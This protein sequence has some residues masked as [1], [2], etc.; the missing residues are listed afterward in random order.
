VQHN[1]LL[2]CYSNS[3][4]VYAAL[5]SPRLAL[6]V[7]HELFLTPTAML[8]DYV[9][10]AA[11][12]LEKP[13]FWSSGRGDAVM[14]G[15]QVVPPQHARHSDYDLC[16]DLGR[17]LGQV[18]PDAVEQ[19]WDDWLRGAETSFAELLAREQYWLPAV[20]QRGR[21][22]AVDPRSGEP[23]G[24]GTPSGKV[25]LA[26]SILAELGYD[27]LPDHDPAADPADA[28]PAVYPLRLMTGGT[29]IDATHQD[30]RQ[31]ASLRRHHP[32]PLV[33]L[34]PETA[35]R[36]AIAEG[37]WVRIETPRG[38]FRQRARLVEGLPAD[39]VNA[40]RWWY[41]ER[42]GAEPE[43]FGFWESNVSAYT[44]D[45]LDRCD[46]AYGNWPFR[47]ARCRIARDDT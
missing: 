18:W 12:W 1:N 11:S 8:A 23:Y 13:F 14:S 7:V 47:I 6:S 26:S 45:D 46:P 2:G 28:D 40:E 29:R 30:H 43:L 35:V 3:Q 42:E 22:A 44:D 16:R 32:D 9:L 31:V 41:P 5:R 21:H 24:F 20:A 36:L 33:E 19:V 38:S 25:E 37:D 4:E 27:P 10:P 34:A 39:V 15:E 17:R